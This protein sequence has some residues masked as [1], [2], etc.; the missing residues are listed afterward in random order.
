MDT[1]G[2]A[3]FSPLGHSHGLAGHG[4][5]TQLLAHNSFQED[6]ILGDQIPAQK[7]RVNTRSRKGV[8]NKNIIK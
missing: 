5:V 2:S 1:K 3:Y 8:A 4:S 6:V 7:Q